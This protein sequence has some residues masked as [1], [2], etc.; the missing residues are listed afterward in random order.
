MSD[1][2]PWIAGN[3]IPFF[4]ALLRHSDVGEGCHMQ[5]NSKQVLDI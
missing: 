2:L 4:H 1:S 3:C 5:G